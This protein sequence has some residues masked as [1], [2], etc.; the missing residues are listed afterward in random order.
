VVRAREVARNVSQQ[1]REQGN[2]GAREAGPRQMGK[3]EQLQGDKNKEDGNKRRHFSQSEALHW[4]AN[5]DTGG[6]R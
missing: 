3:R 5:R 4:K 6:G 2:F 1:L